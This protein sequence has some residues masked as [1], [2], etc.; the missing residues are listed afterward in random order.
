MKNNIGFFSHEVDAYDHRK[1]IILRAYYGGEKGWAMEARFWVLNSLIGK[2]E[3]CRLDTNP[4]GEKAKIARDL[5]LSLSELS[6][7]IAVLVGEAE[8]LHNDGGVLWTDQTQEDLKRAMSVRKEAQQ[9]RGG[10]KTALSADIPKKSADIP[11]KSADKNHGAEQSRADRSR[12]EQHAARERD[13]LPEEPDPCP[14]IPT[15]RNQEPPPSPE[16]EIDPAGLLA[17]A[18]E[19]ARRRKGVRNPEGLARTLVT[20]PKVVAAYRESLRPKP[21]PRRTFATPAPPC[22]CG[23]ELKANLHLGE[24]A[25]LACGS[26]YKFDFDTSET[27]YRQIA[28]G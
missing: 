6:D 22:E 14:P 24:G 18:L 17:F 28:D 27:W 4:K 19:E 26:W 16:P 1:F 5:G 2:A 23:G 8:L 11:E 21:K 10:A 20:D 15:P 7:F 9:R 3:E 13:N 25:C 12:E